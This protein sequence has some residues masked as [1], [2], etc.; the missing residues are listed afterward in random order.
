MTREDLNVLEAELRLR[1]YEISNL[2]EP[3]LA[4]ETR[5]REWL[6]LRIAQLQRLIYE[7]RAELAKQ[8]ELEQWARKIAT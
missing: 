8:E 7:H 1:E 4:L 5:R 6:R 2:R 3:Y